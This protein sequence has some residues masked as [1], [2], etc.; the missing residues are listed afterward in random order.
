MLASF[1]FHVCRSSCEFGKPRLRPLEIDVFYFFSHSSE[2]DELNV[3]LNISGTRAPILIP[4]FVVITGF[5]DNDNMMIVVNLVV[6][7]VVNFS[8]NKMRFRVDYTRARGPSVGPFA[9][10]FCGI[11]QYLCDTF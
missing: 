8:M 7:F 6:V 11:N 9:A 4:F 1:H 3:N 10:L 5:N 2:C